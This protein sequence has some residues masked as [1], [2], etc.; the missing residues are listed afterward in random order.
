M[1]LADLLDTIREIVTNS[2]IAHLLERDL[3]EYMPGGMK[4]RLSI[5]FESFS[6]FSEIGIICDLQPNRNEVDV[7]EEGDGRTRKRVT[8]EVQKFVIIDTSAGEME[9]ED[10]QM[11]AD[12]FQNILQIG[13]R[14]KRELKVHNLYDEFYE[15][16]PPEEPDLLDRLAESDE[17]EDHLEMTKEGLKNYLREYGLPVS[18]KKEK[19]KNRLI[20]HAEKQ[21]DPE[22]IRSYQAWEE[23]RYERLDKYKE[24]P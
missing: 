7:V 4:C 10:A 22:R 1:H 13:R 9:L 15:I 5:Q 3:P 18:G 14:I 12:T 6:T 21:G 17:P 24:A 16:H 23:S 11:V 8:Y 2:E 20:A 19:L